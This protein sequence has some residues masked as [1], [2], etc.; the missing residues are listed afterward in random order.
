VARAAGSP[1]GRRRAG[2]VAGAG[3][4][5][6][7]S[8]HA[9]GGAAPQATLVGSGLGAPRAQAQG[10]AGQGGP[11]HCTD[12][13]RIGIGP[14][15]P[16]RPWAAGRC[17]PAGACARAPRPPPWMTRTPSRPPP[18]RPPA[19]LRRPAA[20]TGANHH[21]PGQQPARCLR[22]GP[23]RPRRP[24]RWLR[25]PESDGGR[26]RAAQ[27]GGGGGGQSAM[28]SNRVFWSPPCWAGGHPPRPPQPGGA[29]PSPDSD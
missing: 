29:A 20:L 3:A 15:C 27:G 19:P 23:Q 8:W 2:R 7:R 17:S 18:P 25:L 21:T 10:R 22:T 24:G 5:A 9:R 12:T 14:P 1:P 26:L 11:G 6:P 13:R 16:A 4:A 28:A